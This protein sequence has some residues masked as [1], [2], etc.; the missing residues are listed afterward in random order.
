MRHV[1]LLSTALLLWIGVE[2]FS[3]AV[4]TMAFLAPSSLFERRRHFENSQQHQ[5]FDECAVRRN[6]KVAIF[7]STKSK[8][9]KNLPAEVPPNEFSRTLQPDRI[10]KTSFVSSSSSAAAGSS[11]YALTIAADV[12]ECQALANRFSLTEIA[13]LSADLLL[14]PA[15]ATNS[16]SRATASDPQSSGCV[17]VEGTCR[18]TVTQRCVRTN[19]DFVVHLEFPL[20][21]IVRPTLP[22]SNAYDDDDV[23]DDDAS[24][25]I[26]STSTQRRMGKK[27]VNSSGKTHRQNSIDLMEMQR[28]LEKNIRDDTKFNGGGDEEDNDDSIGGD[29]LMEDESIY[30]V[31]GLIDVGELVSQLFWFKLDP[32]PK[33]PG[34]SPV[35]YSIT[36]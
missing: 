22:K 16:K 25:M 34:T 15:A 31:D 5:K 6:R 11:G 20:Y 30:C 23:I 3:P 21:C 8:K 28:L 4:A 2:F 27:S 14:R 10:L 18:A 1:V 24:G 13:S 17:E 36:G 32:Y 29:S 7:A 12:V 19:E 9:Q 26:P 35:Q 33:K